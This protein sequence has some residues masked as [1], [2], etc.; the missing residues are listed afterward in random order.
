MAEIELHILMVSVLTGIFTVKKIKHEVEAWQTNR[1]NRHSK[2]N[3]Q[4]T[5]KS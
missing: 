2:I 4:F 1:N 3:W 5:S